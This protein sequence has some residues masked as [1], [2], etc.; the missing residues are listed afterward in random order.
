MLKVQYDIEKL[1][2]KSTA[3]ISATREWAIE[4]NQIL[5]HINHKTKLKTDHREE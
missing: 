5:R 4:C 2:V 1:R 3:F